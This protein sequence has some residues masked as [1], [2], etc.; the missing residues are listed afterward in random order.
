MTGAREG[1]QNKRLTVGL[2]AHVDA[3]KTTLSE[4]MLYTAGALRKL[5]RV[6]HGDSFL[7]GESLERERGITIFSKQARLSWQEGESACV[8]DITLLDT[9]GHVDFSAETERTLPVLDLAVLVISAA[10]GIQSH[11]ETLWK[12]LRR[13]G[14]PT[15]L[16]INKMDL[17]IRSREEILDLLTARLGQG[18]VAMPGSSLNGWRGT[19]G[20]R[21]EPADEES[22]Y[23]ALTLASESLTEK[24]LENG[25]LTE[26]DIAAAIADREVFP[27]YF[28]AALKNEGIEALLGGIARYGLPAQGGK[29]TAA[30]A[31]SATETP[32]GARVFKIARDPNG[33]RLTFVKITGGRIKV[34]EEIEGVGKVDQIRLYSGAKYT[35]VQEADAGMICALTGLADTRPGMG[36]GAEEDGAEE[37]LEPF[38]SYRAVLPAG[39]EPRLVY[40]DLSQLAEED[41]KL[42]VALDR[43]TGEITVR[44]M[45]QVQM[46]VLERLA[47]DRFGYPVT[48][49][50]GRIVYRETIADTVEGVGHFEPLR[51]YAEVHLLLEPGERGSGLVFDTCVSEDVLDRNWQRLI[52]SHLTERELRGVLTNAPLTDMKITL[53][54]GRAHKKHTEGGDFR[55]ATFRALRQGLMKAESVLLEPFF[56]Y[57]LEV[58]AD[59]VGRAMTD[60]QRMDGT[61]DGPQQEGEMAILT[62]RAP[63]AQ[64]KDYALEVVNYT[65]GRGRLSCQLDGYGPCKEQAAVVEEIG[66]DAE[67]DVNDPADSVFVSHDG[68]DIVPWYDVEQK[69]HLPSVLKDRG[70]ADDGAEGASDSADGSAAGSLRDRAAAYVDSAASDAELMAIFER[71]YGPIRTSP[72]A[73][74]RA[75]KDK[76]RMMEQ[77]RKLAGANGPKAAAGS[78]QS[79][80]M[81]K[82]HTRVKGNPEHLIIDGY[83]LLHANEEWAKQMDGDLAVVRE[84]L[85][86]ILANYAGFTGSAVTLVFD[87]YKR[88]PG[89]GSRE[90]INGVDVVYTKEGETA[91]VFIERMVYER[92]KKEQMRVVT[93]D[94]LI[95]TLTLGHGAL[96]TSSR[97]FLKELE[98]IE[99]AI[100]EALQG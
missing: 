57:A 78:G 82:P 84:R 5:G 90:D 63:A 37:V 42:S 27:C 1:K 36:L 58:P 56:A 11:T 4:A 35:M 61:I 20:G 26:A 28:G 22:L 91:D 76:Q 2:L 18:F 17:A 60:I 72:L 86:D 96:R 53:A 95:Q 68:S 43:G 70:G 30:S 51:H 97:E 73:G 94:G 23:D 92:G 54:A 33:E 14:V 24:L 21:E 66:Y 15:F 38:L 87:A 99:E 40:E 10:D 31:V 88:V 32:F 49:D 47:Q 64:M 12:L 71:T 98:A 62:G 80:S 7:D 45:G 55:Q 75:G 59:K 48:F 8:A 6:D 85:Q 39:K 79:D 83:N 13:Y 19:V 74:G 50:S 9:P 52:L 100:R 3:G 77:R 69:M 34:K 16:F 44:L 41:P 89:P 25:A 67:R 65:G 81:K 46:E 93:S 29:E